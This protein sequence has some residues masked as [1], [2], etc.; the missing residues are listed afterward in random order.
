MAYCICI[1]F[2]L[3]LA[4]INVLSSKIF[5]EAEILPLLIGA[6]AVGP[7]EVEVAGDL[8]IKKIDLEKVLENKDTVNNLF[9]LYLG[10]SLQVTYIVLTIVSY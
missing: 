3:K 7:T 8:A 4:G 6:V 2:Q 1:S 9:N 10:L 5:T